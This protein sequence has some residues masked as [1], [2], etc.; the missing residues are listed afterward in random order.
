MI[1]R[2]QWMLEII[3]L[4]QEDKTGAPLLNLLYSVQYKL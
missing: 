2:F 1:F 4:Y 3:E